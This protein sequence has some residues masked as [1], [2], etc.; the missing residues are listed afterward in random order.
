MSVCWADGLPVIISM[1]YI[2]ALVL[3]WANKKMSNTLRQDPIMPE[4]GCCNCAWRGPRWP[5]RTGRPWLDGPVPSDCRRGTLPNKAAGRDYSIEV[6]EKLNKRS[7]LL[8]YVFKWCI[9]KDF[10]LRRQI[11][12]HF[13]DGRILKYILVVKR[14]CKLLHRGHYEILTFIFSPQY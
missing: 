7:F 11:K 12:E 4:R 1:L 9:Q 10:L 2:E 13:R 3:F 5:G 8:Y 6:L 14:F